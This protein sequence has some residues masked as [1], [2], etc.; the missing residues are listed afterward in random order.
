M[1]N[2]IHLDPYVH[3]IIKEHLPN[4]KV[5]NKLAYFY[6][7]FSDSTRLKI[8]VTLLLSE[9][10]VNDLTNILELNQ[11]TVSHQLKILKASGVVS[12]TRRNKYIFYKVTDKFIEL[13]MLNGFDY[14]LDKQPTKKVI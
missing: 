1:E 6:S 13:I 10:C 2:I 11:T 14:I 8:L 7:I 4:K 3:K 12:T 9:M 5:C